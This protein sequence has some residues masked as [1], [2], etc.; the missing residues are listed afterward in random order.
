MWSGGH[1][2]LRDF[3]HVSGEIGIGA[4]IVMNGALFEGVR[5]FGGEIGHLPVDSKGPQCSCGAR[6]CLETMAGQDTMLRQADAPDIETLLQ[7]LSANDRK[8][9]AAVRSVARW[10]GTALSNVVN[11]LD[12]PTI[13]LGGTYARIEPWLH[14]LLQEELELRVVSAA[15]SQMRILPSTLGTEAAVRGAASSAV[16]A[17]VADPDPFITATVPG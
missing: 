5:G 11:L 4:G 9:L 3:V 1:E 10:L 2:E 8:A 12:L 13:V 16:R 6:G 15:W 14:D 17:I 7:R